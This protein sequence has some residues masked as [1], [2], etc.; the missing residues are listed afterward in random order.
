MQFK[1]GCGWKACYNEENGRYF[2]EYGGIQS[3]NLYEITKEIYERLDE[4]MTEGDAYLIIY[5]G[6]HMYMSVDDRCGPPYTIVFDDDYEKLCPWANVVKSGRVWSDELT[7]AA[8]EIFASEENNREQRRRKREQKKAKKNADVYE[9][10]PEFEDEKYLIRFVE[11]EDADALLEVYSDKNSLPFF[12]SDNCDGDNFY[13][14]S[15]KEMEN[16]ISFWLQSY[17]NRCFVRWT[18]IDKAISKAIGTIEMFHRTSDDDF[19]D[20]GVLRLDLRSDYEKANVIQEILQLFI[21]PAFELFDC[22]EIISK[23]PIYAVE[24]LEA[25]KNCGFEKS[26]KLLVGTNDHYAYN[27]YWTIKK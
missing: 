7:D 11:K 13:Y 6:R 5:D 4:S 18:V 20:V 14:P 15:K 26:D 12:N 1:T 27:G 22:G 10:C 23:A 16:A 8:V 25:V 3:Y 21:P 2:A 17:E 9:A 24:R 19:N